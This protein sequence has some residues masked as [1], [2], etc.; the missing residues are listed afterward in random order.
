MEVSG[1]QPHLIPGVGLQGEEDIAGG[2][3]VGSLTDSK[4]LESGLTGHP[5]QV[6][7]GQDNIVPSAPG[8]VHWTVF[9]QAGE[10]H[11][12][13]V[14]K[15]NIL[16]ATPGQKEQTVLFDLEGRPQGRANQPSETVQDAIAY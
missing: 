5:P 8:V 12:K 11:F 14:C 1:L 7:V 10:N 9:L 2:L 4:R 16:T 13:F 15:N 3:D 6:D